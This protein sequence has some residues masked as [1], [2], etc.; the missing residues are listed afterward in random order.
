MDCLQMLKVTCISSKKRTNKGYT[1]SDVDVFDQYIWPHRITAI[2]SLTEEDKLPQAECLLVYEG[3]SF[4][5][6]ESMED[7]AARV[8]KAIKEASIA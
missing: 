8:N 1:E 3:N 4:Q 6:A 5:V 2:C 7:L